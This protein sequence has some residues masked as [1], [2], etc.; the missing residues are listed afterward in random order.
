MS[1]PLYL[2]VN[3]WIHKIWLEGDTLL[4]P[5]SQYGGKAAPVVT[6]LLVMT[7]P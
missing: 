1:G 5:K 6:V 4:D 3:K 7:D 2:V